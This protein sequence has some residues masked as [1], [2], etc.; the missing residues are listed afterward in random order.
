[1]HGAGIG[2]RH[3]RY[4]IQDRGR[5]EAEI[6][7]DFSAGS[8]V[9]C[10]YGFALPPLKQNRRRQTPAG[11]AAKSAGEKCR[12]ILSALTD[13]ERHQDLTVAN[14]EDPIGYDRVRPVRAGASRDL[15]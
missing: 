8:D 13:I 6:V 15:E 14:V 10:F 3:P 5:S 2:I 12:E 4:R 1:M 11:T 9:L 7:L